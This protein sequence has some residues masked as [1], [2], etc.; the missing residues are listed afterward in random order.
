MNTDDLAKNE[1]GSIN[2]VA[3]L[4]D[5]LAVAEA[6]YANADRWDFV[7]IRNAERRIGMCMGDLAAARAKAARLAA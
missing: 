5:R 2:W 4:E 3:V 7:A 6:M 1:D